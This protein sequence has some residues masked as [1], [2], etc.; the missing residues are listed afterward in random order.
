MA[1]NDTEAQFNP[2]DVDEEPL[3]D[4]GLMNKTSVPL[5]VDPQ[6]ETI[7]KRSDKYFDPDGSSTQSSKLEEARKQMYLALLSI[8]GH[9]VKLL[10]V[11]V[12]IP[13]KNAALVPHAKGNFFKDIGTAHNFKNKRKLQGMWLSPIETVYLTERGSLITYL[14]D[15]KFMEFVN[16]EDQ[17]FT[18]DSLYQLSMSHLYS[19]AFGS[20]SS[21]RDKY[22]VYALLKRSGYIILEF[23]QYYDQFE[24]WEEL[25]Q[26]IAQP[27]T[28]FS[29]VLHWLSLL[30][31]QS[32]AL[33]TNYR[34][35]HYFDYA[36][37]FHSLRYLNSYSAFDTL[38]EPP[39]EDPRYSLTFNVWKP[40]PSF[41][42]KNPPMP[43]FQVSVVNIAKVP[44]PPLAAIQNMWNQLNYSFR[45]SE[46]TA[47]SIPKSGAKS[48]AKTKKEAP[49]TKKEARLQKR[50]ERESRL[51]PKVLARNNYFRLR[52]TKLKKGVGRS[53]ILAAMDNGIINFNALTETE[54]KLSTP[55]CIQDLDTSLQK[56]NVSIPIHGTMWTSRS[57]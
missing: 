27:P 51:D 46:P 16:S 22:Q 24:S 13:A 36:L 42:K 34:T 56:L 30:G 50:K 41:S 53:I 35:A 9:H 1:E 29:R 20:D 28:L 39:Q 18:Y 15:E 37:I 57:P 40:T 52:D 26:K 38:S 44:F 47:A 5:F 19:L 17:E 23:R 14:A 33:S 7:P 45:E 55:A 25:Q 4:W 3:P 31:A 2:E 32:R 54:F 48:K 11:G 8:R 10:L 12:W 49:P 21:T 43:D 6:V